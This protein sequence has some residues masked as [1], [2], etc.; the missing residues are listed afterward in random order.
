MKKLIAALLCALF[1]LVPAMAEPLPDASLQSGARA[2]SSGDA[3]EIEFDGQDMAL[4]F[5][6]SP[7][8]SSV[9]GGL[10]QASYYKYSDDG[11]KLWEL[12]LIFPET[13]QP[14]M[15]ITPE[16][17][18]LSGEES[19]VVLIVSDS[20]TMEELY[21]LSSVMDDGA[22]PE[23]SDYTITLEDILEADGATTYSG[24]LS[25]VLVAMDMSTGETKDTLVI[26]ETPFRFTLGGGDSERHSDPL[27]TPLP[28]DMKKV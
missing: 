2:A 26:E 9:E 27:P 6:A 15:V 7:E 17:S 14:G 21:Y 4:E 16:Y 18:A 23:G 5:D 8:Y 3:L 12:Y 11:V 20:Q 22:Y 19:S 25:A 10:V 13:T 24:T 1:A 28:S